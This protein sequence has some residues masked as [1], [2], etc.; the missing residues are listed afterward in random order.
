MPAGE[1]WVVLLGER[2]GVAAWP[3]KSG[4][5]G[6][7]WGIYT[8]SF[9][10]APLPREGDCYVTLQMRVTQHPGWPCPRTPCLAGHSSKSGL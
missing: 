10:H 4:L 6:R 9:P 1:V 8:Q 5:A 2:R 7:L 3:G